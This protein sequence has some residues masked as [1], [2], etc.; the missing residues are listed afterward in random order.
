MTDKWKNILISQEATMRDALQVIDTEALRVGLVVD[1][2]QKLLGM[3]TDGDIRRSIL[4]GVSLD[5]SVMK[6]MNP[7]PKVANETSSKEELV[8]LMEHMDILA[9]PLVDKIN[10]VVGLQTLI[11][12]ILPPVY[13]NPVFIMAGGFG[14]R[15]RPLTDHCPKPMLKVGDKPMLETLILN[16]KKAGFHQFY[17]STHY[18]PSV[19]HDYFAD[20]SKHDV[21]ITYVHE[22]TPL[23]TGG[24]LGLLPKN[25]P[26]LPIILMNGDVLTSINF[27]KVLA[28]H[29]EYSPAATMCVREYEYQVPYGVI[30]G[31][32]HKISSMVEKP[33]QRFFINAGIYVVSQAMVKS[34]CKNEKIDMPS[35]L[36]KHIKLGKDVLKFPVH[37]YWLDIG[38]VSDFEKAQV[39][40]PSLGFL[41]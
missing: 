29:N 38:R 31:K 6:V 2:E 7:D 35:L 8:E 37:E 30:E 32:G 5:A 1:E 4:M 27:A 28:F 11:E 10:K 20:G 18:L 34:V 24:S 17:V 22:E 9:I 3:I 13:D 39:D 21:S 26:D 33:I 36:E 15:L 40:Y 41:T 23:G 12:G 19:I 14:T 16:F 25:L